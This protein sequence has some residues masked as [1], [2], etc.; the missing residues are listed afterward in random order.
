MILE[1]TFASIS[2]MVDHI[3]PLLRHVKSLIL[4]IHWPSINRIPNVKVPVFFIVGTNDEIVPSYHTGKLFEAA[5]NAVFKD[6]YE[7]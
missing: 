5:K 2:E 6:M 1:N 7:V 3:F 4:R